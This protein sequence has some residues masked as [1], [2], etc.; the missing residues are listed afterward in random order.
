MKA[1]IWI[2]TVVLAICA[3]V[4]AVVW[5]RSSGD[6]G[7][8]QVEATASTADVVAAK[9]AK[10]SG[11]NEA[12]PRASLSG[13]I[14]R[15][16]D[17]KAVAGALV[18]LSGKGGPGTRA[19]APGV[20]GRS[21]VARSDEAGNYRFDDVAA[22]AY[23]L[24]ASADGLLPGRQAVVLSGADEKGLNFALAPGGHRIAGTVSD[25][26]GG[27]VD[28]AVVRALRIDE[29]NTLALFSRAPTATLA[30]GEGEYALTLPDG[31]YMLTAEHPDYVDA[32]AP[33]TIDGGPR[34]RDITLT[35]GAVIEG[36]V[37]TRS[38]DAVGGAFVSWAS[39]DGMMQGGGNNVAMGMSAMERVTTD[40]AGHF[41]ITGLEPGMRSLTAVADGQATRQPVEVPLG[42]AEQ[43]SGVELVLDEA[44]KISGFVV[45]E[46]DDAR[47]LQG[48]L[49]SS[50]SMQPPVAVQARGPSEE[51]GYF[52]I[53]GVQP[54]TY[55]IS[56]VSEEAL[57]TFMTQSVTVRDTDVDD[58][59]LTLGTGLALRGRVEPP[60]EASLR[61][62]IDMKSVGM[63]N[64]MKVMGNGFVRGRSASDGTFE[65]FPIAGGAKLSLIA[66]ADDGRKGRVELDIGDEPM[67][68]IVVELSPRARLSG[69]VVDAGGEPVEGVEVN[70]LPEVAAGPG[71]SMS[72]D[73]AGGMPGGGQTGTTDEAGAYAIVGLEAGAYKVRVTQPGG[74]A[75]HW[76][77][78]ADPEVPA[79][80]IE[81]ELADAEQRDGVQLR[82]EARDGV[83]RGVVVGSDGQPIPDAWVRATREASPGEY[84]AQITEQFARFAGG[85][86]KKAK[87]RKP[88][89]AR[90]QSGQEKAASRALLHRFAEPPVLTDATGTF[91]IEG[92]REGTYLVIADGPRGGGRGQR[93]NVVLGSTVSIEVEP[94]GAISGTVT[95]GGKALAEYTVAPQGPDVRSRHVKDEGG[96]F[97]I[98]RL[99]PGAYEVTI[100]GDGG[101][102]VA[103]VVVEASETADA[104]FE[105][106]AFATLRGKL[107]DAASGEGIGGVNVV[108]QGRSVDPG[109]MLSMFSGGG[110]KTDSD[111]TFEV[112]R[113]RAGKGSIVFI[114]PDAEGFETV[115]SSTFEVE[116]GEDEDLGTI[117]GA[118]LGDVAAEDRGVLGLSTAV[119]SFDA[120]PLPPDAADDGDDGDSGDTRQRLWVSAV[121]VDGPAAEAGIE[122]GD[123]II[124]IRDVGVE[125]TG[126][127]AAALTLGA[128]HVRAGEN[129]AIEIVRDSMGRRVSVRARPRP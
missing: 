100:D 122:P 80:P 19:T 10:R 87:K 89:A 25:L 50:W 92:L 38:G 33:L 13:Q 124:S 77:K 102:V 16:D 72:F 15:T 57:P 70:V 62:E 42:V 115:A 46:G 54:G 12:P 24:S 37:V 128:S 83:I 4:A 45:A 35:P 22:G 98:D 111:G 32:T 114:D 107:V 28:G 97:T 9:R 117:T 94:L 20:R 106:Q 85:P 63:L 2:A 86:K 14:T 123:E 65:L 118:K 36:K 60:V 23:S 82:V 91:A 47:G 58:V 95:A 52:E 44:F 110:P 39:M 112:D 56:A 69:T 1:R 74:P 17:G 75:L 116:A 104:D 78:P 108:V 30:G 96:R 31:R 120:R 93:S 53:D 84:I 27:A 66:T 125:G 34:R 6:A 21:V 81:L 51:D 99:D 73:A 8:A 127:S 26:M 88:D 67:N 49:I 48:V 55:F 129:V 68:D 103:E 41:R 59:L 71:M 11:R 90:E 76:A 105:L 79:A 119:A 101:S 5:S 43:V 126:A 64:L 121:D 29:G 18:L 61:V 109:A 3:S 7:D 113:I 40:A